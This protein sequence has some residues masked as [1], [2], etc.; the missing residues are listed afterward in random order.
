MKVE[1]CSTSIQGIKNAAKAGADRIELC[2]GIELGG[3]TP[4]KGL[5]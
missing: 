2:S 3:L 4:S 5:I 1:V